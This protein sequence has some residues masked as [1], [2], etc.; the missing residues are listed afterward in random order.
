M[1]RD[2]WPKVRELRLAALQ[3][4][5][6]PLAFVGTHEEAAALPDGFWQDRTTNAAEGKAVRQFVAEDET[7]RWLGS[8]SVLVELP[9][10]P[11][12]LG[13]AATVPQTQVVGVFVRPEARGTGLA[14][15]LLRTAVEWSWTLPDP[16]VE[17]VRLYVHENNV[18]AQAM[19]RKLGFA[20]TGASV[21]F[22]CDT[23]QHEFE[24]AV[25]RDGRDSA[26][27]EGDG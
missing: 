8:V 5:D 20:R 2:D 18:R 16:R 1:Q 27:S 11:V 3:D 7:G 21:P 6:A 19:Y 12:A 24:L 14:V 26:V 22:A 9:G 4:P 15:E 17:R 10:A 25:D 13:T 23:T